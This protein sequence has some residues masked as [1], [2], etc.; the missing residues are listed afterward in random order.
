MTLA[1]VVSCI[2]SLRNLVKEGRILN[3]GRSLV[4]EPGQAG[5][6]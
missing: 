3:Q 5:A 1:A 6:R 2:S 4:L